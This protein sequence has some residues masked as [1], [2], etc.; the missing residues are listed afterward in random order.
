M[1][2]WILLLLLRF[3][4]SLSYYK[5]NPPNFDASLLHA[6][7]I[8]FTLTSN[9]V[10]SRAQSAEAARKARQEAEEK[11][12]QSKK[13]RADEK[14][15]EEE[16]AKVKAAIEAEAKRVEEANKQTEMEN[17][18]SPDSSTIDLPDADINN[19]LAAV[20]NPSI[21]Q[22]NDNNNFLSS[23]KKNKQKTTHPKVK[24]ALR[25]S[26]IDPL[27]NH[28]HKHNRTLILGS[29]LLSGAD[30]K[31]RTQQNVMNMRELLGEL[32]SIDETTR[33]NHLYKAG[34][35][36]KPEDISVNQTKFGAYFLISSFNNKNPYSK[37][38]KQNNNKK[39]K[40]EEAEWTNPTVYFQFA[41]SC[42]EDPSFILDRVRSQWQF[43]GGIKLEV[44]EIQALKVYSTHV[45]WNMISTNNFEAIS[46]E[47]RSMMVEVRTIN[48]EEGNT[49]DP[50]PNHPVPP[51]SLSSKQP[52]LMGLNTK[53]YEK[54]SYEE[55]NHRR[56]IHIECA[57]KDANFIR[58]LITKIKTLCR[59]GEDKPLIV[60][61]W[62]KH[63]LVSEVLESGK[64]S[65]G[66]IKN[67]NK[68]AQYHANYSTSMSQ[69]T[70]KGVT[71]LDEKVVLVSNE[72]AGLE[73]T[74]TLRDALL[75]WVAYPSDDANE[76]EH[77]LFAEVHRGGNPGD[78]VS[79]VAPNTSAAESL[80]YHMNKNFAVILKSILTTQGLT[81]DTI[82]KLLR[83]SVCPIH[84]AQM[85][86]YKYDEKTR[87]LTS[88]KDDS[89]EKLLEEFAKAP[90]FDKK[91]NIDV[92]LNDKKKL[93][94]DRPPPE[95]LYN[96]D[97]DRSLATIHDRNRKSNTATSD[98]KKKIIATPDPKKKSSIA[99]DVASDSSSKSVV[100]VSSSKKSV[101]DSS[102]SRSS[103]EEDDCNEGSTPSHSIARS[104]PT[105]LK[106]IESTLTLDNAQDSTMSG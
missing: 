83:T 1:T 44:K 15:A 27:A 82:N 104:N 14:K 74:I 51:F 61:M 102:S 95:L 78:G 31:E 30:E 52:R 33:L 92:L 35:I 4:S 18:V 57:D 66:E 101:S 21:S 36:W 22:S 2:I 54:L 85:N 103:I 16:A 17:A 40:N 55:Q 19:Y 45:I 20:N 24:S 88:L 53:A 79:V 70:L 73:L 84:V 100:S 91:F 3:F 69:D 49:D 93:K 106:V 97:G 50:L 96:L 60:A 42:D 25:N 34:S 38:R 48:R 65:P 23:P 43:M 81:E 56:A 77:R 89:Q 105:A 75:N 80:I 5:K 46:F 62:G 99:F 12:L 13:D 94:E 6:P 8:C 28:A 90:W 29:I 86:N 68:M 63:V 7:S 64:T 59:F 67:M 9:M 10:S 39:K 11:R 37:Q 76:K 58:W 32:Q 47:L 41:I 26:K 87:T 98:P 71:N 72:E